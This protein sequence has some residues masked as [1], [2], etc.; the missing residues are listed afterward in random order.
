MINRVAPVLDW[1]DARAPLV[2]PIQSFL[3]HPVERVSNLLDLMGELTIFLFTNQVITGILLSM[4]YRP[5]DATSGGSFDSIKLI[6]QTVPAGSIIRGLH[7]YGAQAMVITIFIHIG[8]VFWCGAYKKPREVTWLL[9]VGLLLMTLGLSFTGYLLPWNQEAYWAT[10][11]GTAIPGYTPIIG[12]TIVSILRSGSALTGET[13]T[14]F[15]SI[16]MLL[17]PALL[18][19]LLVAHLGMTVK[20]GVSFL[21]EEWL[22]G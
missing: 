4:F 2:G 22:D 8:R 14:R 1:I 19:V 13:I 11:V 15:Y 3:D 16:H 7:Y 17:L 18:T 5:S 12:G 21:T 10:M 6:M 20:Q 9:G